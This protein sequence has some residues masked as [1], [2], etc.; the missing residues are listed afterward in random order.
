MKEVLRKMREL[1]TKKVSLNL[2]IVIF[3]YIAFIAVVC[4]CIVIFCLDNRLGEQHVRLNQQYAELSEKYARLSD[5]R[6]HQGMLSV[7]PSEGVVMDFS[8]W[9][10][11][12]D[13][14][15]YADIDSVEKLLVC[16]EVTIDIYEPACI[17]DA[18]F[19]EQYHYS[20]SSATGRGLSSSYYEQLDNGEYIHVVKWFTPCTEDELKDLSSISTTLNLYGTQPI[21][22]AQKN[23]ENIPYITVEK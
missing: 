21:A 19:V 23:L 17:T 14:V 4:S 20:M 13:T 12:G 3:Q 8:H 18:I 11:K 7:I 16:T 9:Q 15:V 6:Y 5:R 22:E 10:V 2:W 1:S